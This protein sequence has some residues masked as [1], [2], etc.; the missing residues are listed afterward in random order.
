M[1]KAVLAEWVMSRLT[2]R[3]RAACV[4]GDLLETAA[5]QGSF[6]FW[7]CAARIVLRLIWRPAIAFV[8]TF[9]V[10]LFWRREFMI[11]ASIL[12]YQTRQN[13]WD[14]ILVCLRLGV[15]MGN[16]SEVHFRA[17]WFGTVLWMAAPYAAIRYGLRDKFAQLALGICGLITVA[18]F[19]WWTPIVSVLCIALALSFFVVSVRSSQRRR[20]LAALTAVLVFAFGGGLL[21]MYLRAALERIFF[22]HSDLSR[23]T[24]LVCFWLLAVLITTTACAWIHDFLLQHDQPGS[25]ME[26]TI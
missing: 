17:V 14:L 5:Q 26:P 22:Y 20:S 1:R 21:S 11:Q 12:P 18:V 24:V 19:F 2:D 10:G 13:V 23:R 3:S 25:E 6:W 8:A 4:V 9:Y 15:P 7:L 16:M